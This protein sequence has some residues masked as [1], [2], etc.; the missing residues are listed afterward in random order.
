MIKYDNLARRTMGLIALLLIS[1]TLSAQPDSVALANIIHGDWEFRLQ[2]D[3]LLATSVGVATYDALLPEAT[4]AAEQRRVR[5]FRDELHQLDALNRSALSAG[6]QINYDFLHFVLENDTAQAFYQSYLVPIDA[7]G[8]FHTGFVMALQQMPL[9]TVS[10]Y[11]HYVARLRAYGAYTDQHI[12]LMNTGIAQRIVPPRLVVANV[13]ATIAPYITN[14]P[15]EHVLYQ[16]FEQ[17]PPR[18]TADQQVQLQQ[19]AREAIQTVVVPA[20]Q[21]LQAFMKDTYGPQASE[22]IGANTRP[23][24][25]DW[26]QQR[27]RYFTTLPLTPDEV[28]ARGEREVTRLQTAMQAIIDSL[29]FDGS[30]A[31][32]LAFLRTDPQFYAPSPDALLEEAAWIAKD[33]DGQLPTLFDHLPRLPYGV[34]PVPAAIAPTYTSGRYV[35][36]SVENHRA[37]TYW[38]NTYQLENRP[39]YALPA[40]TLH[41]AV[42]GHHLQIALSQEM[43]GVPAFRK[44]TYLSAYGEGWGLYA[45]SL[46]EEMGIYKDQYQ[47]FGRLTYEMW[48]ACRLVVDVGIHARGWT[49]A[50]AVTYLADRTALSTHEVNTE[51]DRYIGWPG[52][53]LSYKIGEL[54]IKELR[55][56]AETTLGDAFNIREF[57]GVIL[58][59]GSV[60]LFVLEKR[61]D[62]YIQAVRNRPN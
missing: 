57:H 30:F 56:R 41:E 22:A 2:E 36:G 29:E 49:R 1:Q 12:D 62:D 54:K 10:D 21:R 61:V 33:I 24:G 35:A 38:V 58:E 46:G 4:V 50:Q 60:P 48:R 25:Q 43:E 6:G 28:F 39:R 7:E 42:P 44:H 15:E 52:Q 5:Y 11:E 8:G 51:I 59:N 3:P 14:S 45:E 55:Q 37:G 18:F 40:L 16:S 34:A 47:Q 23:M 19:A 13:Q 9:T 32:F 20:M 26:Y 17:L 27:V 31:N 53:A